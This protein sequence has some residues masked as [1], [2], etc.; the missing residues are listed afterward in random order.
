MDGLFP[1]VAWFMDILRGI[2]A[3]I[4][5]KGNWNEIHCNGN[6]DQLLAR[7]AGSAKTARILRENSICWS[8]FPFMRKARAVQS[9]FHLVTG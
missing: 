3:C 7:Y 1:I 5:Q 4:Q 6:S 8:L 9:P 2:A